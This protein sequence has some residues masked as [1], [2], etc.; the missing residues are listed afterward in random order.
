MPFLKHVN[1]LDGK[2]VGRSVSSGLLKLSGKPRLH[3][4]QGF[5]F[6]AMNDGGMDAILD[7]QLPRSGH[8]PGMLLRPP[9]P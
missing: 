4:S 5:T 1:S 7:S 3:G 8:L 6:P 2:H 9:W